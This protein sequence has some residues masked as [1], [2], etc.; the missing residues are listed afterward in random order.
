MLRAEFICDRPP[1]ADKLQ[2]QSRELPGMAFLPAVAGGIVAAFHTYL[3]GTG[4][5]ICPKGI[6][7]VGT[8]AQQSL[9]SFVLIVA[10]LVP[11]LAQ[12]LRRKAFSM[13]ALAWSVILG[14]LF[15]YGCVVSSPAPSMWAL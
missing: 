11:G 14:G 13:A 15:A 4:R 8:T 3:D 7:G 1:A 6:L 10:C 9:A 2:R 12:D 5:L